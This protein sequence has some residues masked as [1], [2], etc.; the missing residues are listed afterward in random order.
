MRV[1]AE[2]HVLIVGL[3]LEGCASNLGE[4]A[5]KAEQSIARSCMAWEQRA[6]LAAHPDAEMVARHD[7]LMARAAKFSGEARSKYEDAV[8]R[9]AAIENQVQ[10][11]ADAKAIYD[12]RYDLEVASH[13]WH[14]LSLA[15]E[16]HR[17]QQERL[18]RLA[19]QLAAEQHSPPFSPAQTI[20]TLHSQPP[21]AP[22]PSPLPNLEGSYGYVP[23]P[24]QTW[25]QT[26]CAQAVPPAMRDLPV[27]STDPK[28][29]EGCLAR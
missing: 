18:D 2:M 9:Q 22:K 4:S 10:A 7:Q 15:Q 24:V 28:I 29:P 17:H 27:T 3:F 11:E 20:Y 16:L 25:G 13:C 26:P 23:H 12:W 19:Q 8:A 6:V 21:E 1:A 5:E 14:D